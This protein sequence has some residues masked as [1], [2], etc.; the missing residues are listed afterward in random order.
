[1]EERVWHRSYVSG[2]P[3]EIRLEDI[4]IPE[5]LSRTAQKFP[6]RIALIFLGKKITYRELD[7]L[8]NRFAHALLSLGLKRGDRIALLMPNIPQIVISYFG[9]WRAGLVPV[10]IN[11]LYTDH[12][13]EHQLATSGATAMVTLDLL[14]SRMLA[15][16]EK[17]GTK[18]IITAHIKDYLP[19]PAKQLFPFV[20]KGMTVAY[21]PAPDYYDFLDLIKPGP[22][23][24][25]GPPPK[26]DDLALIP[27]SG[28]TTGLAKGVAITH[29][30]VSAITQIAREWF[31]DIKD[32]YESELAI[33]PFFHMA[34]F[35]AVM[36]LC[37]I[38]GWT[39]VLIPRPEPKTIMDM[40][41]K[42]KSTIFL[43]V[44][45]IYVGVLAMPEFKKADLTFIKGFFSGAAPLP[46]DTINTLKEATNGAVIV[47][48]YGMTESTTFISVTPWRGKLKP[49][50]VGVPLPN[51][52]VKI[53]DVQTG[54][55][56]L[57][58][59][60]EGE[61]IFRGP[62]M[63]QGYYNMPEETKHSIR[64]GWFYTGDIGKF[65]ED[66]YL[67][68]VDRT[69]DMIIAGGYNI[70]PREIDEAL[71]E[72]PKVL[73]ACTIGVPHEYRGETVKSFIVTK[74][75]QTLTEEELD[76]YCRSRLSPYKVPRIYEFVE[77]LPKSAVGKILK[78][79]L[80]DMEKNK[81]QQK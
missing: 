74:P 30:N 70:F 39:A 9:A 4:T 80:R 31:F 57:P 2:I 64:D 1:M 77:T 32:T 61:I 44:P 53:M 49:G 60:Q 19:F 59:G 67:Y 50:S 26:L 71:F 6:S 33:F 76:A 20:K 41:L 81:G 58:I 7:L 27:Y 34:G 47:E 24:P 72:H 5:I 16:R 62:N 13:I 48:G 46:I 37:V 52:D 55:K 56:E 11:P 54:T 14:V 35:T 22:D 78:R 17:T 65:D 45:T 29:R 8:A 68:I 18:I 63:C 51:I 69:K 15:L 73:E 42:Y 12:E 28:G 66:G 43:A 3:K 79:E 36:N 25:V 23:T 10:P 21:E 75:G 40:L 38:S